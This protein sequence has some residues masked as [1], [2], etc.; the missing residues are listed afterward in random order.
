MRPTQFDGIKWR[1]GLLAAL[2]IMVLTVLPQVS[3]LMDRGRQW[4]GANAAMHP[5]EV[6]YSG[7]VASLIRG[8]PRRNDPYTGRE[9]QPGAPAP[10]SLF[11]IQIVPAY[12]AA[13]P[14]RWLG[15]T[16]SN[17]FMAFPVAYAGLASLAVFWL[18]TLLTRDERLAAAGTWFILGFGTLIARQGIIRYVPS[19]NFLIP[20]WIS[21]LVLPPSAYHLPFARFYQPAI[22]FPLFFVL[23]ALV[24]IALT[25]ANGRKAVLAASGAGITF[26]MLVFS[27]FYLW[28]AAAAW[29]ACL[30]VLWFAARRS[31]RRRTLTVFGII[32]ALGLPAMVSYFLMLSHRAAS[33]DSA[34]ALVLT[35]RPDLFRVSE[36]AV[37]IVLGLLFWG[38]RRRIFPLRDVVV[39]FTASLGLAV[40]AVF[41]QQVITGR[42]LQPIHYEWFIG[43]YLALATLVLTAGLW[44]RNQER[45][46]L[47][48]R[49]LA[50]IA[51][52]ALLWGG[53]EVWLA[54]SLN[55][56][57]NR[58]VDEVQPVAARLTSLAGIDEP[59]SAGGA[60]PMV[61]IADLFLADRLPTDAPQAVLWAPRMLVFPGVAENENRERFFQQLYYLGYDDAKFLKELDRADWNF[62]AGMFPYYRLSR[63]ISGSSSPIFPEEIRAQEHSYLAYAQ[64]FD[65]N[66]AA[67]PVLSYLVV[68]VD[69]EP[70]YANVDRWYERGA[71]ER[72]GKFVLYRV[73]LRQ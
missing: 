47:T 2:A 43:N 14:A 67:K 39:L 26:G 4:H 3:F 23:C 71:G 61:L 32:T 20:Q 12:A 25:H 51:V 28:T 44:W 54:S 73:K 59:L 35:R 5:D 15:L 52:M 72:F 17:V 34:Q 27:Y 68:P 31:E 21:N 62:Y 64:S 1:W 40:L 45:P 55:L 63:V 19:L 58:L 18:I 66:R 8:R 41:N 33:V 53:G 69:A 57:H 16:A 10:E 60:R 7:Y 50:V 6:A 37:M 49:R 42:S 24:W 56:D 38:A 9:D 65:R 29:L 70:N 22:A 36:I 48:N 11:S 13:L 46:V 30:G